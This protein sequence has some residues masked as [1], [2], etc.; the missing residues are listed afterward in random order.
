[1]HLH[2][3]IL[4]AKC[5]KCYKTVEI[6][7]KVL[8]KNNIQAK[9]EKVEN[10]DELIKYNTWLVPSIVINEEVVIKGIV[11]TEKQLLEIISIVISKRT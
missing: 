1:M 3:K 10:T 8:E 4:G 5:S 7:R 11:P 6:V 2:I 9:V